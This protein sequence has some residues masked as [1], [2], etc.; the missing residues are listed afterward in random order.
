VG[1]LGAV[2]V[3]PAIVAAPFASTLVERFRGDRVLTAINVLRCVARWR[4]PQSSDRPPDRGDVRTR[5]DRRGRRIARPPDPE[6]ALPA[7]ART[8][9]ELIAANVAL[10]RRRGPRHLAGRSGRNPVASTGLFEA[11]VPIAACSVAAAAVT[12]VRFEGEVDARGGVSASGGTR[13]RIAD[14][15]AVLRRY[16]AATS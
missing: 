12:G 15:P 11:S 2:R 9:G 13:V 7:L 8:P 3:I 16:P 10:E 5:G 6:C 14:A 1:I 4:P